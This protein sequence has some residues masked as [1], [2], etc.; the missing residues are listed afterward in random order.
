MAKIYILKLKFWIHFPHVYLIR[1]SKLKLVCT[2]HP[3]AQSRWCTLSLYHNQTQDSGDPRTRRCLEFL[4]VSRNEWTLTTS[5][6]SL[7]HEGLCY[8][9][10][11]TDSDSLLCLHQ[12]TFIYS[13]MIFSQV[14]MTL[15][16]YYHIYVVKTNLCKRNN[17]LA[18]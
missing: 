16:N 13:L 15:F 6:T 2:F 8:H 7:M 1:A 18:Y 3:I 12:N 4:N 10:V 9:Y 17:M 5:S 11:G 14:Y